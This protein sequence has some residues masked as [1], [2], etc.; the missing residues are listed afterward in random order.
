MH[1]LK[2]NSYKIKT[3]FFPCQSLLCCLIFNLLA[4]GLTGF[5]NLL[6]FITIIGSDI[7][8]DSIL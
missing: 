6:H 7:R 1:D 8:V 3:N 2:E 5:L 4:Y